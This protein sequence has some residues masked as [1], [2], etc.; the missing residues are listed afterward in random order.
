M[1]LNSHVIVMSDEW[2]DLPVA[3]VGRITEFHEGYVGVSF[4]GPDPN[5]YWFYPEHLSEDNDLPVTKLNLV[6]ESSERVYGDPKMDG[7]F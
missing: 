2:S 6:I 3:P 7:I 1:K 4:D 5:P